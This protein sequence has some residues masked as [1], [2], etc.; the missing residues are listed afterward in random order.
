MKQ[1]NTQAS[2]SNFNRPNIL[3]TSDTKGEK[4]ERGQNKYLFEQIIV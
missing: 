1:K 4:E 2:V 3:C